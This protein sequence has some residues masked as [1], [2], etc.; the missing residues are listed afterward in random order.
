MT[1][2]S[3]RG[4][5]HFDQV[6]A[7]MTL[8]AK[9]SDMEE[10]TVST[11]AA[12]HETG[13]LTQGRTL[14][15]F[16]PK[17]SQ[18]ATLNSLVKATGRMLS[19][20]GHKE[21]DDISK[22]L[23]IISCLAGEMPRN[24]NMLNALLASVVNG[25]ANQYF[26]TALPIDQLSFKDFHLGPFKIGRLPADRLAYQTNKAGSDYYSRCKPN[27]IG[28]LSISREPREVQVIDFRKVFEFSHFI[29]SHRKLV[30]E[31]VEQYYGILSQAYFSDFWNELNEEQEIFVAA[32]ASMIDDKSF[33]LSCLDQVTV[34]LNLGALKTSYVA[35]QRVFPKIELGAVDK[36]L[37]EAASRLRAEF[38]FEHLGRAEV[39]NL[40]RQFSRFLFSARR[41]SAEGK[42]DDAFLHK[43]IALDLLFGEKGESTTT[44][45]RRVAAIV[46]PGVMKDFD[47]AER[48]IRDL[49]E[50]RSRYVHQGQPVTP[51]HSEG[52]DAVC[53]TVLKALLR[54]QRDRG[55]SFTAAGWVRDLDF[56]ASAKRA[57]RQLDPGHMQEAGLQV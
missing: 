12:S 31:A 39:H 55:D 29:P 46:H 22:L 19:R 32:G 8:R 48:H 16:C 50:S 11:R 13:S 2:R 54:L 20:A 42:S 37:P 9:T 41:H 1:T 45:A 17:P 24:K 36:S 26:V 53:D 52:I 21:D 18:G 49:Y 14:K 4:L 40:L 57:G 5:D 56:V 44:V 30:E 33:Q 38:S 7:G 51:S 3:E 25:D 15:V 43:V 6:F 34:Y 23:C 28:Q 47:A 27:V 10:V 35:S